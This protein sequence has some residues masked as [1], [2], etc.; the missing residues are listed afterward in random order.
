MT[1]GETI[2]YMH[3]LRE[4]VR[5]NTVAPNWL[6]QEIKQKYESSEPKIQEFFRDIVTK[7]IPNFNLQSII[8]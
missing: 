4:V 6:I 1:E 7:R 5:D 2:R 8:E 3:L